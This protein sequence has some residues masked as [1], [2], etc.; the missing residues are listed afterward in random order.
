M[1]R[2]NEIRDLMQANIV[3][4][5]GCTEPVAVALAAAKAKEVIFT[6][7]AES[8]PQK[9]KNHHVTKISTQ[10]HQKR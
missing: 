7:F 6:D 5:V 2:Q 9:T 1:K 4:A 10:S 8:K 3:L